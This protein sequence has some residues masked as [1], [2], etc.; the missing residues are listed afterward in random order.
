MPEEPHHVYMP[1][2]TGYRHLLTSKKAFLQLIR[3]FIKQGWAEQV[4]EASLEL[5]NGGLPYPLPAAALHERDLAH[6]L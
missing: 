2:D 6:Y 5:I 1:H 3:S 4:D